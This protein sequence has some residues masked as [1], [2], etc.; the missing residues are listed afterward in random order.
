M[1]A[2]LMDS[3]AFGDS[4]PFVRVGWVIATIA[5]ASFTVLMVVKLG[6]PGPIQKTSE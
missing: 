5:L 2:N 4:I 1:F 3:F 6:R